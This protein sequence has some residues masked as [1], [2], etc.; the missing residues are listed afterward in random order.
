MNELCDYGGFPRITSVINSSDATTRQLLAI[1]N[2][3][4]AEATRM[5]DWPQL[6]KASTLTLTAS[7][8]Q[9]LPADLAEL[10]DSTAWY[11]GDMTPLTGPITPQQWQSITQTLAAPT[12]FAFRVSQ[13]TRSEEHN[14]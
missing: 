13:T 14:V 2:E 9:A 7:Q 11:T 4:G 1:A 8:I 3:R 5:F 10:L 12:K 6:T